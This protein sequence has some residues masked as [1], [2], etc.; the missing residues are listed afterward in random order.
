MAKGLGQFKKGGLL[1]SWIMGG[2]MQNGG[3][4]CIFETFHET[5]FGSKGV[6]KMI[7][8]R[9]TRWVY[10]EVRAFFWDNFVNY[11]PSYAIKRALSAMNLG[12]KIFR[13]FNTVSVKILTEK[14]F[15]NLYTVDNTNITWNIGVSK[16]WWSI[17]EF[18]SSTQE[19]TSAHQNPARCTRLA[20]NPHIL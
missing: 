6:G 16:P 8:Q 10:A 19:A 5:P 7:S 12:N 2:Q 1:F 4:I 14:R 11:K 13:I 15:Q 18:R 9:A 20:P 17:N 3:I